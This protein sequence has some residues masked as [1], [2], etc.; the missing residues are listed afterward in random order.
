MCARRIQV[1]EYSSKGTVKTLLDLH[2]CGCLPCAFGCCCDIAPPRTPTIA[3]PPQAF[4]LPSPITTMSACSV[5]DGTRTWVMV[6]LGDGRVVVTEA[7]PGFGSDGKSDDV[8]V[9]LLET[10][11]V[12]EV[13]LC[14]N[15]TTLSSHVA[16]EV[17]GMAALAPRNMCAPGV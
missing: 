15:A 1:E 5:H 8:A 7:M 12:D 10:F 17:R 11:Q 2:D 6:G 13:P 4:G 16:T 3:T 9:Q 14:L